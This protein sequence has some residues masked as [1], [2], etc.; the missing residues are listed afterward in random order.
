MTHEENATLANRSDVY[1]TRDRVIL[2][3]L[4]QLI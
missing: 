3:A 4:L 2:R 1:I